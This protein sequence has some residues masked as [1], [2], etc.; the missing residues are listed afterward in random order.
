M[1]KR[2]RPSWDE[3]FMFAALSAA[4][5]SSCQCL[6]TGAVVVKDKR[7][8]ASGYNGAPEGIENCLVRGCRKEQHHVAFADKGKGQCRGCHG[9]KNAMD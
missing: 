5:R 3:Y 9:E 7:I 4:T 8:V 1:E 2:E 6:F